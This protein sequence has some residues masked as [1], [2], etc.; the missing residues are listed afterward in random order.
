MPNGADDMSA[1]SASSNKPT[2]VNKRIVGSMWGYSLALW[3][4]VSLWALIIGMLCG[5]VA[6]FLTGISSFISLRT[7]AIAQADTQ[8][9]TA[10]AQA[11]GKRA[12]AVAAQATER[13]SALETQTA[14]LQAANTQLQIRLEEERINRLRLQVA[15]SSRHLTPEQM[16]T[17]AD[18]VRGRISNVIIAYTSDAESLAFAQDIAF[19]VQKGGS[20]ITAEGSGMMV[21]TPYGLAVTLPPGVET[22]GEALKAVYPETRLTF[23]ANAQ[24]YILVG[25][26][27]PPF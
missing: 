13:T 24:P 6:V 17:I 16:D 19:A 1:M 7:S 18:A 23:S 8:Q 12:G 14:S 15:I 2:I 4:K 9:A 21:P 27:P 22:F 20:A 10:E 25:H 3:D 26:K 5:A 11:E